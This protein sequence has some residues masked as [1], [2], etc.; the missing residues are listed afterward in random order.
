MRILFTSIVGA[1]HFAP[2]VPYA[3]EMQRQGHE[4]RVAAPEELAPKIAAAGLTHVPVGRPTAAERDACFAPVATLPP[5]ERV[6]HILREFFVGLLPR[7]AF[8]ALI[9]FARDWRPDLIV[10]EAGEYAGALA[11]EVL[12]LPHARV[13]VSNGHA[14]T[15]A[16]APFDVLREEAGLA[17]DG[18]ASLRRARAFSAFPASLE[19][20]GADGADLPQVRV[21]SA[22]GPASTVRPDWLG[23][24]GPPRL[25]VTFGT[26]MG[27]SDEAKAI[28]RAALAAVA[29]LDI[30][31]LM[32]TGP[33]MDV[34]ALGEI[35][36]NVTLRDFV[37]QT[38]VFPHVSAVLC[39][40]GSG[41]VLGALA[42]SLPL[43]VTPIGADQ[44]DNAASVAAA[45]AG[46]AVA[47]PDPEA[48][49]A[50]LQAVLTEPGYRQAAQRIAAEM[51]G[52][53]GIAAA[54][55]EMVAL[56]ATD[57]V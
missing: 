17:P 50:A 15:R 46:T 31:A 23:P 13:S 30:P 18:G 1:G 45:G 22:T 16:I 36:A 25:Y 51:A 7:R 11:A 24:D 32:T 20:A 38:D 47:A 34:A 6:P 57:P 42:A 9:A 4:V 54:V 49:A 14:L 5:P 35:P 37:P 21:A 52:Q 27:S 44:P 29:R 56:A 53:S 12:G 41:S 3:T 19:P 10:R 39:H 43:V 8:P 2:L 26:V 48:M 33:S 28:F 55:G 40:G